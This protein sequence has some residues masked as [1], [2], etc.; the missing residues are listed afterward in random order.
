MRGHM[1]FIHAA[2]LHLDSPLSGLRERA[3]EQADKLI[4]ATRRAF[5]KLVDFGTSL[6][7][8]VQ[9]SASDPFGS[10]T[11]LSRGFSLLSGISATALPLWGQKNEA[12]RSEQRPLHHG[13]KE[14]TLVRTHFI[15]RPAR[16]SSPPRAEPCLSVWF[17]R[18]SSRTT[19]IA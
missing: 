18:S 10:M 14:Q 4:G 2:D 8:R 9:S 11:S 7:G 6:F 1:R 13:R 19:Y 3:G 16:D 15:H 5:E 12:E 17:G